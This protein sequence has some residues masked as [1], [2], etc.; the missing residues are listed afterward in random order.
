MLN[1]SIE[2]KERL[3]ERLKK[4][5]SFS[6][7]F[8]IHCHIFNKNYVP[9]GF[10]GFRVPFKEKLLN[11]ISNFF[12]NIISNDDKDKFS[13]LG[14]FVELFNNRSM[15]QLLTKLF[16]YYKNE[17]N[18]ILSPLLM[19]M[20]PGIKGRLIKDYKTQIQEAGNLTE[21]YNIMPFLALD[22][23][24]DEMENIFF[25]AFNSTKFYGIKIY[26]SLGYLP[27]HPKL[28]KI[29]EICEKYNIPVTTHCGGADVHNSKKILNN[30]MGIEYN[31]N[32]NGDFVEI[33]KP[34]TKLFLTKNDYKNYFNNPMNW[35]PVLK[36]F[37][38][39]R[40][41]FA[42]F[43]GIEEWIKYYK[44]ENNTWVSRI[45][46]FMYNYENVFADLSFT[47][48][49]AN[50]LSFIRKIVEDNKIIKEKT[51]FGS[52]YYMIVIKGHF[53][54]IKTDF[55]VHFGDKLK[56]IICCE[57]PLRFLGI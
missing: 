3:S 28:M 44:R 53:R 9:D 21:R 22:P 34:K 14:Y 54:S 13:N 36:K 46:D 45:I 55:F 15:E 51:L 7:F 41:N 19:D 43:G 23:N 24:N 40:L 35:Q 27:T 29:F 11:D 32:K 47:L 25:D 37:P 49:D 1:I 56:E 33:A 5:I 31:S 38:K 2:P 16:D 26:P 18:V 48:Y 42:H 4:I 52:D 8:D 57:N 39:L 12:K 30:I 17:K 10:L 20:R 6:P 50:I